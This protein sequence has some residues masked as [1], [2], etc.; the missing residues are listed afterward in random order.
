MARKKNYVNNAAF[1]EAMVAYRKEVDK[2][3]EQEAELP[4]IPP[5]VGECIYQIAN[6]LSHK[7]NFISYTYREDMVGDGLENAIKCAANFDP[8]KSQNPFAYFTQVIYFAFLRRIE[9]E[10]KQL[11]VKHKV[12]ENSVLTD[13][14]V[15]RENG[16]TS[17]SAD[18]VDLDNDYMSDFVSSYEKTMEKKRAQAKARM[19]NADTSERDE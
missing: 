13:T 16:D 4:P 3:R 10:K 12:I 17:G 5:Y 6:R 9:K 18:Y 8:E 2:A 7:S 15:S 19:E 11:Y 14:I 1:Y